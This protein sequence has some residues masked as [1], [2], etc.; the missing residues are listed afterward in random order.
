LPPGTT[1]RAT[2]IRPTPGRGPGTHS[3][4]YDFDDEILPIGASY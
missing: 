3:L 4:Y 1:G 2:R